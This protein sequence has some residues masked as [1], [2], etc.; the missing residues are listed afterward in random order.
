MS[1]APHVMIRD[2]LATLVTGAADVL[3]LVSPVGQHTLPISRGELRPTDAMDAGRLAVFES[4]PAR[5][6][7]SPGEI[8]LTAGVS[9]PSCLRDLSALEQ[10]GLVEADATGWRLARARSGPA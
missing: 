8:A 1:A 7:A 3:D 9:L 2:G 4:V 6:R 10:D 5:R